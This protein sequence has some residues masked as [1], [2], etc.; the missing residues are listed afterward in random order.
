MGPDGSDE[1]SEM[2]EIKTEKTKATNFLSES[3]QKMNE[4]EQLV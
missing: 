1:D 4:K 3:P 2:H